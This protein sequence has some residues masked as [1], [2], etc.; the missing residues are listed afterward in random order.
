MQEKSHI[1]SLILASQ[2][3]IDLSRDGSTD[4]RTLL[5]MAEQSILTSARRDAGPTRID[6][7]ILQTYDRLQKL[8][9]EG[10]RA[11][12]GPA[13]WLCGAGFHHHRPGTGLT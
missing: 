11:V 7:I 8:S 5:D 1:R 9:G 6:E 4:A 12:H 2:K 13:H 3:V 10:Q